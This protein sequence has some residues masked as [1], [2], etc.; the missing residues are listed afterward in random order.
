MSK[1]CVICYVEKPLSEFYTNYNRCKA[2][3]NK[4]RAAYS[5]SPK[6][7][8]NTFN[9]LTDE[10]KRV[11]K[12]DLD[13]HVVKTYIAKNR[14]VDYQNLCGWSRHHLFDTVAD[15]IRTH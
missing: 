4:K 13:A 6:N 11:I 14:N 5:Q 10:Q 2:C 15:T 7:W 8:L 9:K 12:Q 1:Q 3:H